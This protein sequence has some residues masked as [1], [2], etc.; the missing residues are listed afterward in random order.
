MKNL[1]IK[2]YLV[3]HLA[4][5][6]ASITALAVENEGNTYDHYYD[7]SDGQFNDGQLDAASDM[8]VVSS[9][10]PNAAMAGS[11]ITIQGMN[12]GHHGKVLFG[13][14]RAHTRHW[15]ADSIIVVVPDGTGTVDIS[16]NT[17]AGMSNT[18]I[19]TYT[20]TKPNPSP[21]SEPTPAPT[22]APPTPAP[23]LAPPTPA[24]TLAPP[25]PAP[26]LAPPTPAPT[27]APPTPAPTLTPRPPAP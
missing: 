17:K 11:T 27:L 21:A 8:P 15:K 18:L 7:Y 23:T 1:F 22:L 25:T 24:P 13:N 3:L 16:V 4:L 6:L 19:F 20:V 5:S 9:N 14:T 2:K 10:T 12:F 26:T